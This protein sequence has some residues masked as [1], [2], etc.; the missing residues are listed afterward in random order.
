MVKL[1]EKAETP[2]SLRPMRDAFAGTFIVAG[3]T[4]EDG[5]IN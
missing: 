4:T 2:Y 3:D 5:N 1:G